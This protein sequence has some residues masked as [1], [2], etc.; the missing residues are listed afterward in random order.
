MKI[1]QIDSVVLGNLHFVRVHTDTGLE[2]FG[3]SACWAYPEAVDAVI[4]SFRACLIGA[5]PL[6]I[7]DNWHQMFRMG[8]FRSAVIT[9]AISSIDIALWDLFGKVTGLPVWQLL[10]GTCRDRLRLM[11][12]I[13]GADNP[14]SISDA[15]RGAVE[16]GYTAI[17][18]DP[19]PRNYADLPLISLIEHVVANVAAAREIAGTKVD[20]I[21]E[22]HRS[23]TPLQLPPVLDAV[24]PFRPLFIEDPMQID[25]IKAQ[26]EIARRSP[27]PVALG[28]RLNS[29][30]EFNDQIAAGGAIYLRADVGLAGGISHCRKILAL[31]EAH[32]LIPVWH[33]WQG[34]VITAATAH[35][36][37]A[38]PNF[39]VLEYFPE[40]EEG[41]GGKGYRTGFRREGGFLLPSTEP[42]LGVTFDADV[43]SRTDI[44]GR[45]V[46]AIPRRGDG[47]VAFAV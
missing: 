2:G 45:A 5:D 41:E 47:S 7:E 9:G 11:R 8:P 38:A 42:G 24:A 18:F 14:R 27:C 28:E 32:H 29:L 39:L 40:A 26:G 17:K 20:L 36:C 46:H 12:L 1:S 37:F 31:A 23:L 35:L 19:L 13:I 6:K 16:E 15:V 44:L 10:G 34:P 3:Q 43:V 30:W 33:N 21:L 22:F 4:D 25:S